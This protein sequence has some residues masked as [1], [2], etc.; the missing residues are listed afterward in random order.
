MRKAAG[1]VD[2][3]VLL[4]LLGRHPVRGR[5]RRCD[6]ALATHTSIRPRSGNGVPGDVELMSHP[7][8]R[9]SVTTS[10]PSPRKRPTIAAPIP[11]AAPVT[12][13]LRRS[14]TMRPRPSS[15]EETMTDRW[16]SEGSSNSSRA[17]RWT[18]RSRRS[19]PANSRR[20]GACAGDEARVADAARPDGRRR[21]RPRLVH[22]AAPRRRGCRGGLDREHEPRLAA[23]PRRDRG[24]RPTRAGRSAGRHMAGTLLLGRRPQSGQLHDHRGR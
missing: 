8:R 16:F 12:S 7:A 20:P 17:R 14:V 23:S 19:T 10:S 15:K 21:A 5:D 1:E 24:A 9:S 22:S 13:A 11:R 6:A 3:D 4:P 18:A 2:V